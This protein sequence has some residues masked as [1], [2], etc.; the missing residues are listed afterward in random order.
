MI[1]PRFP[2]D[3][4]ALVWPAPPDPPRIRYIGELV[5]EPSLGMRPRGL[6]ALREVVEGPRPPALFAT[7]MAVAVDGPR[8][9]VADPSNPRG[10]VVH[11]LDLDARAY[12][13][14]RDAGGAPL[15]WPIDVSAARGRLAIGDAQRGVF[16]LDAQGRTVVTVAPGTIERAAAVAI[17]PDGGLAVLDAPRHEIVLCDQGGVVRARVGGRGAEPG[18]FN[19]PAGLCAVHA[20][21]PPE[22]RR[23]PALAP[24]QG[25]ALLIADSMNFRVQWLD[26]AGG[27]GLCFG[28][29]GDAAG[30]FALPRDV[31]VD[32]AGHIYVLDSQFENVQVFDGQGRLLMAFGGE[33]RGPGQFSV[34][35]GITIDAQD[36]IW[37]ADTYNRRVQV[38]QYL[39]QPADGAQPP[40]DVSLETPLDSPARV[41]R[42]FDE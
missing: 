16:V 15:A 30:D 21:I 33:G 6:D 18:R 42:A 25:S 27:P 39:A 22:D 11:L 37:I 34:P 9:Y 31:A 8:V 19:F 40:A 41:W 35:S 20:A 2:Y 3:G 38:F 14:V 17:L 26:P 5:G 28:Q 1:A 32:S 29:K 7:P 13:Q 12:A 10:P 24:S 23:S 4:P 36:R